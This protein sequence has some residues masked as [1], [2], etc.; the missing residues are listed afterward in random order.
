M[1]LKF[2]TMGTDKV[3]HQAVRLTEDITVQE[4]LARPQ[5]A[6]RNVEIWPRQVNKNVTMVTK[7]D[8]L[9]AR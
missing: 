9:T 3:A 7:L 6:L 5:V 4:R 1:E 2:A 8:A